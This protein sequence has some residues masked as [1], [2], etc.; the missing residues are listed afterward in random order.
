M[1][2]EVC[3]R[4]IYVWTEM[5]DLPDADALRLTE[6]MGVPTCSDCLDKFLAKCRQEL[7]EAE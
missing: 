5:D 2:C 1:V 4:D 7:G 3:K 6:F